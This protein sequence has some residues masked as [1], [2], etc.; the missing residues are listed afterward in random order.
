VRR[1]RRSLLERQ[2]QVATRKKKEDDK[3]RRS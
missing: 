1:G 3:Y 2:C